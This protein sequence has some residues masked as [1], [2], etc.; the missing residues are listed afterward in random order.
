MAQLHDVFVN[1]AG[2]RVLMRLRSTYTAYQCKD[3]A[4]HPLDK[5]DITLSATDEEIEK[6]LPFCEGSTGAAESICIQRKFCAA[7][8]RLGAFMLHA[9]VI[10]VE[11]EGYGFFG[12][13]GAG[14][15]THT[16]LWTE[17]LGER[18]RIVNG[19]KPVIRFENGRPVAY[20]TPWCG[21]E[22]WNKNEG[23]ELKALCRIVKSKENRIRSISKDEAV[24]TLMGQV[25]IP[26]DMQSAA[27]TL[28]MLD[29]LIGGVRIYELCCDVSLD[30]ARLSFETMKGEK[31]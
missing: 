7:L 23:V 21:K 14:K 19:D 17:L 27:L 28:E 18:A 12:L 4:V 1:I 15:S 6:E 9:S 2:I 20:G 16:R 11:N 13:S 10:S 26:E 31:A 22:L 3:Y 24:R 25:I 30:A 8:P 5:A 29:S